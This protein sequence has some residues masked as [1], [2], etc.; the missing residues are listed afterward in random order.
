MNT[1][2]P[3][4]PPFSRRIW[5]YDSAQVDQIKRAISSMIGTT[6]LNF[7]N[8]DQL[9][10]LYQL[11]NFI[12]HVDVTVKPNILP[13]DSKSISRVYHKYRRTFKSYIRNGCKPEMTQAHKRFKKQLYIFSGKCWGE[14]SLQSISKKPYQVLGLKLG[15]VPQLTGSMKSFGCETL[16]NCRLYRRLSLFFFLLQIINLHCIY[17]T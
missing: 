16:T 7:R 5:H 15:V 2:S 17:V 9:S 3:P 10:I 4:P 14:I 13:W 11:A 12:P 1:R 8:A 6:E